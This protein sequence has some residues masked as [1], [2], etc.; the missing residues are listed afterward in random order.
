M[1]AFVPIDTDEPIYL[2]PHHIID[3]TIDANTKRTIIHAAGGK[4]YTTAR[5]AHLIMREVEEQLGRSQPAA[6]TPEPSME[7]SNP[8]DSQQVEASE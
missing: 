3:I 6:S 4:K 8:E 7:A 5:K 1:I 2:A